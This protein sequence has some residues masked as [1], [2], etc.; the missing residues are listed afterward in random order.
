MLPQQL[1]KGCLQLLLPQPC[2]L[3]DPW[4]NVDGGL[5]THRLHLLDRLAVLLLACTRP[6]SL[7]SFTYCMG[8]G[9]RPAARVQQ[10][11]TLY[12]C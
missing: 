1:L 9:T 4:G 6:H 7:G 2:L 5:L 3:P 11:C 12:P 10:T 8:R